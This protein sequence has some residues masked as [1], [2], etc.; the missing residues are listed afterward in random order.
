[1]GVQARRFNTLTFEGWTAD[2]NE[3]TLEANSPG[4]DITVFIPAT[5][6]T[7]YVSSGT[8]VALADGGTARSLTDPNAD[9]IFFWDD[10][11]NQ[12]EFL[13]TGTGISISG[14]TMG[15]TADSL[16]FTE[17]ADTMTLDATTTIETGADELILQCNNPGSGCFEFNGSGAFTGDL[18]HVHQHTGNAGA[19]NLIHA[20]SVDMDIDPLV[21][22]TQNAADITNDTV[23]L[24]ITAVDDDD[25]NYIPLEIRDDE[26]NNNDLLFKIDYTGAVTTGIWSGTNI[27][28]AKG[29]TGRALSDP[30]DDRIFFWDD[31]VGQSE[32]LDIGAGLSISGTTIDIATVTLANG[33]TARSLSDPGADRIMFWDDS[34]NQTEFLTAGTNLTITNTTIAAAGGFSWQLRPQQAKLPASNP[35]AIDAGAAQWKGLFDDT[36]NEC[37]RWQGV[38]T[39]YE[40]GGLDIDLIYTLE[41]TSTNDVVEME[42]Y[43]MAVSDNEGDVDTDSFDS[44]NNLSSGSVSTTAGSTNLLT[45]TLSNIDS[46][47]E[48]DLIIIKICRDADDTDTTDDDVE[49]R[50][51]SVHE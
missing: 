43:V 50:G 4:S 2:T 8:D 40:G 47:A 39:P 28:L 51:A 19:G 36:T 35:M 30:N 5:A 29:G 10:S 14:I 9:R 33:G 13:D 45:G 44:V 17:F 42:V 3:L 21:H 38:L 23:L 6:G 1:M 7:L 11:S 25:A 15:V 41:T 31:G 34:S 48:D 37:A 27:T 20:E 18:V 49:L 32:W 24:L 26:D 46:A 22:I 12:T 16:D